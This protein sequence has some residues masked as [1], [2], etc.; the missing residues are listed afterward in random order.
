MKYICQPNSFDFEMIIQLKKLILK[1]LHEKY[2]IHIVHFIAT[3][4]AP[5]YKDLLFYE[6]E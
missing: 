1:L 6:N 2:Y 3:V 5:D 4:F